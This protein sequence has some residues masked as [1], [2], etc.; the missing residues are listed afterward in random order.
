MGTFKSVASGALIEAT[1]ELIYDFFRSWTEGRGEG[2]FLDV[3]TVSDSFE[4]KGFVAGSCFY[5]E[6]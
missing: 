2:T 6:I 4:G 5:A 1:V 3:T